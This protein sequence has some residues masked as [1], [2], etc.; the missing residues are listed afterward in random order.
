MSRDRCPR[1]GLPNTFKIVDTIRRITT[2]NCGLTV[3]AS[4]S[5]QPVRDARELPGSRVTLKYRDRGL[6]RGHPPYEGLYRFE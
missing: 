1:F 4:T 6:M 2:S 3:A 5:Y